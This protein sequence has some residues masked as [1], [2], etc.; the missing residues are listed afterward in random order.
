MCEYYAI[1]NGSLISY[2]VSLN[3]HRRHLNESQRGMVAA[4]IANL[5]DGQNK[6]ATPIGVGVSSKDAAGMLNVGERT[7][8]RAKTVLNNGVEELI[9]AVKSGSI[10][11]TPAAK[12]A[13]LPP[14]EQ[15]E[16]LSQPSNQIAPDLLRCRR[17]PWFCNRRY[18]GQA[19]ESDGIYSRFRQP[20]YGTYP[21]PHLVLFRKGPVFDKARGVTIFCRGVTISTRDRHQ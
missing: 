15:W 14:D 2:I 6:M 3:L 11:L 20:Q 18:S 4:Q 16:I 5:K 8:T 12:I 1:R 9:N 10:A 21:G 19:G 7:V 17:E 13:K